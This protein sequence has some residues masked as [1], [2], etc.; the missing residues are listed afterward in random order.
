MNLGLGLIAADEYLREGDRRELR[1][2]AKADREEARLDRATNRQRQ[3]VADQRATEEW[4]LK[5]S[6]AERV[7]AERRGL[8]DAMTTAESY[9]PA[10]HST[11]MGAL[12]DVPADALEAA[13][14]GL[15]KHFSTP[16]SVGL[17]QAAG[18]YRKA[19]RLGDAA[20]LSKEAERL[21]NEG[22][23]EAVSAVRAGATPAEVRKIFDSTGNLRFDADPTITPIKDKSGKVV[24]YKV[25]GSAGGQKFDRLI[26]EYENSAYTPKERAE[27]KRADAAKR[28]AEAMDKRQ[29]ALTAKQIAEID[30]KGSERD[31][32]V[33]ALKAMAG[34]AD[35]NQSASSQKL[36]DEQL[37]AVEDERRALMNTIA[38][39]GYD[40][41]KYAPSASS[42]FAKNNLKDILAQ[43]NK[44]LSDLDAAGAKDS[45]EYQE[46]SQVRRN[47]LKRL[48]QITETEP[49]G[50]ATQDVK[51]G[52][53]VIG[54]VPA[55]DTAAAQAMVKKYIE[56]KKKP[57]VS[58]VDQLRTGNY[59]GLRYQKFD[60]ASI[61]LASA[62]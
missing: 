40:P 25:S 22:V 58:S 37:R 20:A 1:E 23:F 16:Y 11:A 9:S 50:S 17:D 44:T 42:D 12:K 53:V 41:T 47:V 18:A 32:S 45:P 3:A 26:S 38:E 27:M 49:G 6:E 29:A 35:L 5:K 21:K 31:A 59:P 28:R 52:G 33:K 8:Q 34:L 60:P 15:T 19:G 62:A 51:V 48:G 7:A 57:Q 13:K 46:A 61:G 54:Q 55:G 10:A 30:R 36:T 4:N 14:G 43:A 39:G 2:Q 56:A 24:D